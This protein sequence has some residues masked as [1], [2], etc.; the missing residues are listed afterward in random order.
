MHTV[1]LVQRTNKQSRTY[2]D[3]ESVPQM[4]EGIR[5]TFEHELSVQ[6][7]RMTQ[8]TYQLQD[9]MTFIDQYSEIGALV[10]DSNTQ[11]YIP[12]PREWIKQKA[13]TLFTKAAQQTPH[14]TSA[15]D[16]IPPHHLPYHQQ[17]QQR[18]NAQL[19]NAR[20]TRRR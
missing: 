1:L 8:I 9:L 18:Y 15:S 12:H 6:N 17:Q 20:G 2:F 19:A 10:L 16:K 14:T 5:M 3:Y 4:I 13:E 11:A 7:P